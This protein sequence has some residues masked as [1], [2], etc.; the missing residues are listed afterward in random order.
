MGERAAA[1]LLAGHHH[2]EAEAVRRSVEDGAHAWC[3]EL[4]KFD[5]CGWKAEAASELW[6]SLAPHLIDGS[7]LE[8]RGES[9]ERWRIRW[10]GG[11]VYEEFIQAIT[12]KVAHEILPPEQGVT[13]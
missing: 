1:G 5:G 11:H 2:L 8:F 7:T 9:A 3:I 13:P 10:E 12:W 4:L 6:L